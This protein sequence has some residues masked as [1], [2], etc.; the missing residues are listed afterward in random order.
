MLAKM[1]PSLPPLAQLQV[2]SLLLLQTALSQQMAGDLAVRP[3]V[4]QLVRQ[5][6]SLPVGPPP[7]A[8]L[9]AVLCS[10]AMGM[11]VEW[12]GQL[13]LEGSPPPRQALCH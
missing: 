3:Q 4:L 1:W 10:L 12:L 2:L 8:L 7:S 6:A 9:L 13:P 11:A 5:G